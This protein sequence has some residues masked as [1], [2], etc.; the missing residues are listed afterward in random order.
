MVIA[1]IAP[2]KNAIFS[3]SRV[4]DRSACNEEGFGIISHFSLLL[5]STIEDD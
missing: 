1:Q 5:L 4:A 2:A 3:V